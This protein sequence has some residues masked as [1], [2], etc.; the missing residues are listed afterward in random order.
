VRFGDDPKSG[1]NHSNRRAAVKDEPISAR[2]DVDSED[3]DETLL[4]NQ[5]ATA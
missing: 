3:P 5:T 1:S 4:E 2:Q